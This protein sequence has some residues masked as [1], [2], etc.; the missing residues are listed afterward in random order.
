MYL[1]IKYYTYQSTKIV[2]TTAGYFLLLCYNVTVKQGATL[3]EQLLLPYLTAS[4][5][6][7]VRG[8][9]RAITESYS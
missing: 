7:F 6:M 5:V 4:I 8:D 9:K 3:Y 1:T 2:G